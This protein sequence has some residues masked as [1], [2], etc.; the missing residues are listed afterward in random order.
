MY[1]RQKETQKKRS[2]VTES[3]N[4][5]A[6]MVQAEYVSLE[7]VAET[8]ADTIA[9]PNVVT[10]LPPAPAKIFNFRNVKNPA[11]TLPT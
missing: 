5:C 4:R 11:S 6:G 7:E 3:I 10:S 1:F 9:A 2:L 8:N